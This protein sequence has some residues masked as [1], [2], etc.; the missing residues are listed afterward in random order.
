[1]NTVSDLQRV[2]CVIECPAADT[3][4]REHC[5]TKNKSWRITFEDLMQ[6]VS[7][8]MIGDWR[9]AYFVLE[10]AIGMPLF[11]PTHYGNDDFSEPA[12]KLLEALSLALTHALPKTRTNKE[13]IVVECNFLQVTDKWFVFD[14]IL[15][16]PAPEGA[17]YTVIHF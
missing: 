10:Q 15:K 17:P 14:V 3:L 9:K 8:G 1:M 12:T 16:E 13:H 4:I 2:I 6:A 5:E 11:H 7:F